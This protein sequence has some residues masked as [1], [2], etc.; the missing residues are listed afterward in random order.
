[1]S[2]NETNNIPRTSGWQEFVKGILRENPIFVI[3]LGL[4]PTLAVTTQTINGL[5][6]GVSVIFVLV[7][8]NIFISLLRKFIPDAVRIP[9]YIMVIASFVT[10]I[11]LLMQAFTPDINRALGIY[12]PLIVVNCIILGRAEAFANKNTVWKS[13]LDGLGMGVGFTLALVVIGAIREI[14][15]NGTITLRFA[16]I[17]VIYNFG[18]AVQNDPN[19]INVATILTSPAIVMIL[20]PGGFL[21][22]GLMLAVIK[23]RKNKKEE[24]AKALKKTAAAAAAANKAA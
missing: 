19:V 16:G 20:P 18:Q 21:L 11:A 1:M 10:L 7:C 12:I 23:Y 17:G 4:C 15:G 24:K 8:S 22:M 5:A 13:A 9:A 2:T 6:M 3:I 14:F